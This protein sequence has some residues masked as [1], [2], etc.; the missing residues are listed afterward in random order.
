[1]RADRA[2]EIADIHCAALGGIE[3]IHALRA[4]R[5]TGRLVVGQSKAS[6]RVTAERPNRLRIE[7]RYPD[8]V[9]L[10]VFD[11]VTAMQQTNDGPPQIL[12]AE[13]ASGLA[14]AA[15]FDDPLVAPSEDG[16][17]VEYAGETT[18]EGESV[19]RLLVTRKLTKGYFLA[20]DQ[21]TYLIEERVDA[22]GGA[23]QM[24]TRYSDY[25]PVGGVLMPHRVSVE[26]PGQPARVAS[27]DRI[28]PNPVLPADTFRLR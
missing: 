16:C 17:V 25:R 21:R 20:V 10:A 13:A 23:A 27:F 5:S 6:L 4:Y 2:G 11:G 8:R 19:F 26:M 15:D 3:R 14:E 12:G 18:V 28:E 9:V 22:S 7:T 24:L 1:M